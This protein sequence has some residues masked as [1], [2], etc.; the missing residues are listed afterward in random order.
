MFYDT[1]KDQNEYDEQ[2]RIFLSNTNTVIKYDYLDY[3]Q[4]EK[5]RRK[6]DWT[7][8]ILYRVKIKR[9]NR[10]FSFVF[11][12]SVYNANNG[13]KPTDYSVLACIQKY[14]VGSIDDFVSEF[15]YKFET[16]EDVKK[17]QRIYKAVTREYKNVMRVFGDVIEQLRE[18]Q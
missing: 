15:G 16:W 7:F 1:H 13:K 14:D 11:H 12:D 8:G 10:S 9:G 4:E 5:E 17:V 6:T 3:E 18:I 2:A